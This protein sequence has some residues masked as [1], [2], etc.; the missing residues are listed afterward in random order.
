MISF[1][2]Y[3]MGPFS[4]DKYLLFWRRNLASKV[5]YRGHNSVGFRYGLGPF[6]CFREGKIGQVRCDIEEAVRDQGL[7]FS[8]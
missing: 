2:D 8:G 3:T 7:G 5:C 6:K 4:Y 1:I